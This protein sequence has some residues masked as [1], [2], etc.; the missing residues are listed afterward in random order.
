MST[1]ITELKAQL[2]LNIPRTHSETDPAVVLELFKGFAQ[3]KNRYADLR[4]PQVRGSDAIRNDARKLF[5]T[6]GPTLW[7]DLDK[8]A[9]IPSWLSCPSGDFDQQRQS[10]R[11]YSNSIHR[12]L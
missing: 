10:R 8:E 5:E 4:P 7:P 2:G 1:S 6:L 12:G 11:F 9:S 3:I